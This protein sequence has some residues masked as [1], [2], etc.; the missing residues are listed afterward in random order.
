MNVPGSKGAANQV[1]AE[2]AGHA[3]H[4]ILTHVVR[5]EGHDPILGKR[6]AVSV[7]RD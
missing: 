7:R 5:I 2:D 4:A 1:T 3:T 6:S